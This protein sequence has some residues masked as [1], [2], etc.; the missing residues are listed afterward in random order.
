M[1]VQPDLACKTPS[2]VEAL[3][4]VR[5]LVVPTATTRPP[6]ARAALMAAAASG[7]TS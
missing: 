5:T 4:S 1:F 2:S 3:S 6:A 7:V